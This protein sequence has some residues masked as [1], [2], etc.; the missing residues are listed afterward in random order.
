MRFSAKISRLFPPFLLLVLIGLTRLFGL[1]RSVMLAAFWGVGTDAAAFELA[2]SLSSFLF[3]LTL[4]ALLA[5]MFVPAYT[6]RLHSGGTEDARRFTR[7]LLPTLFT[8]SLFLYAPLFLFPKPLL[9]LAAGQSAP[10]ILEPAA[11][12]LRFLSA[13][14]IAMGL[15]SLFVFVLQAERRPLFP[16]LLYALSSLTGLLAVLLIGRRLNAATLAFVL[17]LLDL[18][19]L[20]LLFPTAVGKSAAGKRMFAPKISTAEEKEQPAAP[21]FPREPLAFFRKGLSVIVFSA[22]LPLATFLASLFASRIGGGE[23]LAANGYAAKP[24]LL[25]AALFS[26]VQHAFFYPRLTAFAAKRE[27][28]YQKEARAAGILLLLLSLF[29]ALFFALFAEPFLSLLYLRGSFDAA[30]L[31]L[32]ASFLRLYAL[33]L[34]P[35]TLAGLFNDLAYLRG[36]TSALALSGLAAV[37]SDLF[38]LFL[39]APKIGVLAVPAAFF[40]ASLLYTLAGALLALRNERAASKIRLALV[41]SDANIGGA[42]RQLL[43]YLENCDQSQ[44]DVTVILPENAALAERVTALGYPVL[45]F[46]KAASFSLSSTAAYYRLFRQ[47]RFDVLNANASLSARLA[48]FLARVPVR[49]YTRHCVYPTPP[50]LRHSLP[51][52]AVGRL[53]ALLSPNAI[54]VA[55]KAAENL[56]G[57]GIEKKRVTVIP[58]GVKP[59]RRDREAGEKIR[60]AH[61]FSSSLVAV[62]CGRLEPDKGISTLIRAAS[63]LKEENYDIRFLVVGTGSEEAALMALTESLG[64]CDRVHFCGFSSDVTPYLNAAQVY[65]NCSV[66]TEATSLAIA[67]AMSLSL[68]IVATDYGGNPEMVQDGVNGILVP[69]NNPKALAEAL[70]IL[71]D[72]ALQRRFGNASYQIYTARYGADVMARRSE[73][74]YKNLFAQKARKGYLT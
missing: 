1:F 13:G 31:K 17:F 24:V 33:S 44:F 71:T 25:S 11:A 27:G 69:Q 14:K 62:I 68:P 23:A 38:L 47:K 72:E 40:A 49:V 57:M 35:L 18:L 16:A 59:I 74:L 5:A 2:Y 46:G 22:F 42:G 8:V 30:S 51:R 41:L 63:L 61:G 19:V 4:G 70:I 64:L 9:A 55:E 15:A 26:S 37:A 32:T 36:K 21:Y 48:A 73:A 67:E 58:N 56:Y 7:S 65:L 12:A 39:L 20:A 10:E 66:G 29:P 34:P 50:L 45:T 3:D 52:F 60:A 28:E 6:V 43:N 53:S 54:A